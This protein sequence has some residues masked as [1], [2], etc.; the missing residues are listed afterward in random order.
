MHE[1]LLN[2]NGIAKIAQKNGTSNSNHTQSIKNSILIICKKDTKNSFWY[3]WLL[4][5][6]NCKF[7]IIIESSCFKIELGWKRNHKGT[8]QPENETRRNIP[9]RMKKFLAVAIV[10]TMTMASCLTA[11]A[12][13]TTT[14]PIEVVAKKKQVVEI[15]SEFF[16]EAGKKVTMAGTSVATTLAGVYATETG[17]AVISPLDDVVAMLGLDK[18]MIPYIVAYDTDSEAAPLAM[19]VVDASA[20][21]L[22][23]E[24]DSVVTMDLCGRKGGLYYSLDTDK[25][26]GVIMLGIKNPDA[27]KTYSVVCVQPGGVVTV[28]PDVD[29]V[30]GTVT[31]ELKAGLAT[32]A[33]VAK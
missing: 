5:I 23:A 21:A 16:A 17:V 24:V 19:A 25:S 29:E 2:K 6:V 31:C 12:K 4:K 11:F 20:K 30:A 13:T 1:K 3:L 14:A 9:M 28:L 26:V 33:I 27:T 22:G 32:Y 10:A 7:I 8:H 15:K 18:D